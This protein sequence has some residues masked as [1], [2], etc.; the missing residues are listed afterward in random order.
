[1]PNQKSKH[2][3]DCTQSTQSYQPLEIQ[4]NKKGEQFLYVQ[5][6]TDHIKAARQRKGDTTI[7]SGAGIHITS[8]FQADVNSGVAYGDMK[9]TTDLLMFVF[10]NFSREADGRIKDG[11]TVEI[12][13]ARGKK[14]NKNTIGNLFLDG[15]LNAEIETLRNK[16]A[17]K[18]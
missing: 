12:F 4:K 8:V 2:R 18:S 13:V 5:H 6:F 14:F 16:A 9:G 17:A 10:T 15:E 3:L 1:M 11:A 7:T